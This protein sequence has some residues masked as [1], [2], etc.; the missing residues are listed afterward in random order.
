MAQAPAG[1]R[2]DL[3]ICDWRLRGQETAPVAIDQVRAAFGADLPVLLITGDT[4]PSRLRDAH[5]TGF[6][7][8][9]KPVAPGKLRAAIG[10]L[11]RRG[12]S[13]AATVNPVR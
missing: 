2:P 7:L 9:H 3:L 4:A 10:N 1:R 12:A 8:L 13:G 11:T 6:I 5:R